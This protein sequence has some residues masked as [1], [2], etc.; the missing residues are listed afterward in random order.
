MTGDSVSEL[1]GDCDDNDAD[2][3]PGAPEQPDQQ[4]NDCDGIIDETTFLYDDDGDGFTEG[5]ND[6]ND[7]NPDISP[8]AV[9]L[10]DGI[11]NNCNNLKDEQEGCVTIDSDPKIIGGIQMEKQAISIGES[12]AMSVFVHELD[13]QEITYQWQADS[14]LSTSGH[15]AISDAA[16]DS[17]TWTA[18]GFRAGR[19]ESDFQ[20]WGPHLR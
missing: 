18:P 1:E 20:C 9:E 19:R 8:G 4:D 15:N 3:Y 16:S 10:C 14:A 2:T 13:G 12:T 17:I 5:D 6:C 7:R 11:D